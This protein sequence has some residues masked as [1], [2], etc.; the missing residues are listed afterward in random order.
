MNNDIERQRIP[1][2]LI[3]LLGRVFSDVYTHAQINN[4]FFL[5]DAPSSEPE[6]NK[7]QKT[8][9]WLKAC[10]NQSENPLEI[11]GKLLEEFL[12]TSP[13]D[14]DEAMP[15]GEEHERSQQLKIS[16]D[17]IKGMLGRH[18]L[19]YV[20]GGTIASSSTTPTRN[21]LERVSSS[22][23]KAVDVE[24]RRAN[25]MINSDPNSAVHFA[26]NILEATF[27]AYLLRRKIA[28]ADDSDTLSTL[29]KLTRDNMGANPKDLASK[30][31]K[32][33]ASGMHS[34]VDGIMFL[35][36]KRSSSHGKTEEQINNDAMLPRH[37][38]LAVHASHTL[39]AY[40]LECMAG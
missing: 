25:Q 21:L 17:K 33:I 22:G 18:A 2:P 20:A 15:W 19:V 16:Q 30:D 11:L 24:M 4:L 27:K 6:G 13:F 29:W 34:I 7:V 26:G 12:E 40:V 23:L 38:R 31:L 28:F 3:G 10:N 9:N 14:H 8:M 37:A 36:N 1:S 35:R 5:A 39:S 32:K